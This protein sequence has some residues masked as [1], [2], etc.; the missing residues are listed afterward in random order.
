MV[1]AAAGVGKSIF[2]SSKGQGYWCGEWTGELE[3]V[4][5]LCHTQLHRLTSQPGRVLVYI[6]YM[7]YINFMHILTII[8][9]SLKR[10]IFYNTI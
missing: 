8:M 4:S 1:K 6:Q 7:V 10:V 5:A 2:I 3:S 9:H